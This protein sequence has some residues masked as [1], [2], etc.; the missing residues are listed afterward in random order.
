[1]DLRQ[2][3]H[4]EYEL[5]FMEAAGFAGKGGLEMFFRAALLTLG[6]NVVCAIHAQSQHVEVVAK[7]LPEPVPVEGRDIALVFDDGPLSSTTPQ[8]LD[9]LKKFGMHA[10]FSVVGK[11]VEAFPDIAKRIAADGHEIVNQTYSHPDPELT[12]H[13][14]FLAEVDRAQEVIRKITGVS[15]VYF[16]PPDGELRDDLVLLVRSKG[17]LILEPTLDSGDWRSPPAGEVGRVVLEGV[18]PGAVI[19]FHD[20]FP[21]SVAEL[22]G[23][24]EKLS[25]RGY[26]SLTLSELR[27]GA[28]KGK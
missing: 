26:R 20:S 11:N 12:S 13:E 21:K 22:P 19:L 16:C 23:I 15:P 7:D 9:L 27:S 17:Y 6:L 28:K 3:F 18:T 10:T 4:S 14:D 25:Q 5:L 2:I 1:M 24:V 8:V